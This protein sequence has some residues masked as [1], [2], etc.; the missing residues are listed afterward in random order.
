MSW[1]VRGHR[2]G[3]WIQ[4]RFLLHDQ[5]RTLE[6][7]DKR[8]RQRELEQQTRSL[9]HPDAFNSKQRKVSFFIQGIKRFKRKAIAS[10]Y[11]QC[12][13]FSSLTYTQLFVAAMKVYAISITVKH[14]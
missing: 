11:K 8:L 2:D 4:I 9:V 10:R 5:L 3:S 13:V 6:A 7:T 12:R 1:E 14:L